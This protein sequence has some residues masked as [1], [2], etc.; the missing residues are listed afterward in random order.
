[1]LTT[2]FSTVYKTKVDRVSRHKAPSHFI[3]IMYSNGREIIVTPEHPVFV[4]RDGKITTVEA[5]KVTTDDFAPAV[6]SQN[7]QNSVKLCTNMRSGRKDVV[8]PCEINEDLSGFLGFFTSEGYSYAGSSM[9][10]GLSNTSQNV[11]LAMKEATKRSFGIEP[12]DYTSENRTLR[13]V[14][15]SIYDFMRLNFP[16][17]TMKSREKRLPAII[18]SSD[19]ASRVAF[20]RAAF[21]GDGRVEGEAACY[22]T[23]SRGL[24]EDY[25]DLLLTLGIHSRLVVD[26]A[27]TSYK[28]YIT[29][30]SLGNFVRHVLQI[31]SARINKLVERSEK[32]LRKHDVLPPYARLLIKRSLKRLGMRYNGYFQEHFRNNYGINRDVADAYVRAIEARIRE[33]E[34]SLATAS[35]KE[36]RETLNHSQQSVAEL[37]GATR[38]AVDYAE[39]GGYSDKR[40]LLLGALRAGIRRNISNVREDLDRLRSLESFRWLR[41]RCIESVPNEGVYKTNFVYDVT[42]EPT[43]AFIS[44]GVILHNTISIAKA[45]IVVQLNARSSILAAAN[46][47]FG[48]YVPQRSIS[49]N[50]SEL[51]VTII[52]RFDLIFILVDRPEEARD[53]NMTEHIL[54]LHQG[55][56]IE[57]G[58][59]IDP[60]LLKKYLYYVRRHANPKLSE[61]ASEKIEEFFLEM[62]G[63]SEGADS[64][65][66]I[67]MRQLEAVIRLS[68]ARAKLALKNE[69]GKEDVEPVTK[70]MRSYLMQVGVDR[71][72]GK[73]DI[74]MIMVGRPKSASDKLSALFDLLITMEK[75]NEMGPIKREAFIS[76]AETEGFFR[77][78]AEDAVTKWMNDGI[79]YESKPGFIKKT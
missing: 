40:S 48:R 24:A 22:R 66:P 26:R 33:L 71:A 47:T 78:F 13:I 23:S 9:E 15:K 42:V 76:R 79:I 75:E 3:R 5:S 34:R 77:K 35:F 58:S 7:F 52:S 8:L 72:T 37:M 67:T 17:L 27:N 28:V 18:F 46:P 57:R 70:L 44:H 74:D 45:G 19:V 73:A 65:V 60:A 43:H 41:V 68:E 25:Q 21:W 49:E 55:L 2:D 50:I 11:I 53:R 62:R 39:Q 30:D 59:M 64:P 16:K 51:P 54:K 32:V 38:S 61:E 6:I 31:G 63:K 29:G 10:I 4:Y 14:S 20:L 56:K 36:L 69:V 12:I 1:M